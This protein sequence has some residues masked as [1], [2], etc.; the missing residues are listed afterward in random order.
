MGAPTVCP[1][2]VYCGLRVGCTR[3]LP[4]NTGPPLPSSILACSRVV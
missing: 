3:K 1:L 4:Q 2:G